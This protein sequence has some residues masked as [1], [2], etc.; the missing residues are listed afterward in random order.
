MIL[1]AKYIHEKEF[2]PTRELLDN[3]KGNIDLNEYEKEFLSILNDK[4]DKER[5]GGK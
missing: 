5:L 4:G 3:R 1:N 2:V